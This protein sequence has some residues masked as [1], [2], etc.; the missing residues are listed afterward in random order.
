MW[1]VFPI[2]ILRFTLRFPEFFCQLIQTQP[3]EL[4]SA[5]NDSF[6]K[7]SCVGAPVFSF[8]VR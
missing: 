5:R 7:E 1:Q 8:K 4:L 3:Q 6:E 2:K